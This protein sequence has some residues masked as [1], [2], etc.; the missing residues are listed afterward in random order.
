MDVVVD[1]TVQPRRAAVTQWRGS[2]RVNQRLGHAILHLVLILLGF[3]F[4]V[5]LLWVIS[6]SLKLPNQVFVLPVVWIPTMFEWGNYSFIFTQ[7]PLLTFMLNTLK[8][9]VLS[10]IGVAL[11]ASFVSYSLARLRWP[12][13]NVVFTLVLAT[14]MLPGIVTLVPTFI[15]YKTIGWLDTLLP[16][17]VPNWFGGGAFFIFL[18][19][20]FMVSLPFE[21]EEAARIDGASSLRILFQIILPLSR[22]VLATVCVFSFLDRYNDFLVPLIYLNSNSNFTIQIGLAFI[23]GHYGNHWPYVMAATL[24]TIVPVIAIFFLALRQFIGGIQL[25]G[26][27]GR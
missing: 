23:A 12:G 17:I 9:C 18:M 3:T 5:P 10:T 6:T 13:R 16:L 1:E 27:A 7:V 11:S 20:Q 15:V 19:R 4:L 14:V 25:T 21:L 22:P 26:L 24:V 2:R 8:V